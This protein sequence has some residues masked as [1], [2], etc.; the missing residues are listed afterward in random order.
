[1]MVMMLV[2]FLFVGMRM[3]IVSHMMNLFYSIYGAK[4]WDNKCNGV[5]KWRSH[6]GRALGADSFY[7]VVH[8]IHR[9][10][11]GKFNRRDLDVMETICALAHSAVEMHMDVIVFTLFM[12]M[13]QFIPHAVAPVF[14]DM[15]QMAFLEK[16]ESPGDYG[17]VD[18]VK[19][20]SQF[21]H[22]EGSRSFSQS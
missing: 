5:A 8:R 7:H 22:R 15:D 13:A 16:G 12:S 20:I 18:R 14:D 10:S 2:F 6:L 1:M 21:G 4:V 17:L 9:V 3:M 11:E 19:D